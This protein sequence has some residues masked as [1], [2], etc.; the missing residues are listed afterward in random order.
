MPLMT[1]ELLKFPNLCAQFYRLLVL[2]NDIYPEK[3]CGLPVDLMV[4]L[5][6]CIEL[7]LTNFGSDI[8]QAC[9][10]FVQG[11]LYPKKHLCSKL[12]STFLSR[13]GVLHFSA[14]NFGHGVCALAQTIPEASNG[15][16]AHPPD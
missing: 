8:V 10:D 9:L 16:G 1:L 11:H 13:N 2:I 4:N 15:L 7:G 12:I 5:L 14:S 3:I 6:R